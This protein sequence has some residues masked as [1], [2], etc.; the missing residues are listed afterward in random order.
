MKTSPTPSYSRLARGL[1]ALAWLLLMTHAAD[2]HIIK[3][4]GG[5]FRSGFLHPWSGW[6]HIIAM[7]GVGIWGAQ[8]GAPAIWLLPVIFPIV[9]SFG[10]LLGLLN[11]PLPF[12]EHSAEYGIA[13]SGLLLGVMVLGDVHPNRLAQWFFHRDSP[14]VAARKG[15]KLGY[16]LAAVM[17]G[18]F[19][20]CHGY[21]H[22]RELPPGESG[23]YYSIGFVIATGTLHACGITLGLVH[24]WPMGQLA[25]RL[26]GV[27]ILCG[28]IYFLQDDIREFSQPAPAPAKTAAAPVA[29]HVLLHLPS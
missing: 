20:L 4:E 22:G 15:K 8:I 25:L 27:A 12:G 26:C 1:W 14:E 3:G 18:F 9:M 13:M 19:G 5:G 23:L 21:A 6:D 28:G 29:P 7:V 10:G 17:V 11:V 16:T 2:A 24:R